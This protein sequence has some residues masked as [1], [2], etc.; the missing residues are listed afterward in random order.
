MAFPTLVKVLTVMFLWAVCFPL[1]TAGIDFAPHLTFATLRALLAGISLTCLAFIL[2]RPLPQGRR[3][4]MA[5]I[6]I[7]VTATSVGFFGMFHAAEF[8]APGLAT[9]VASTQPLLAAIFAG[10]FLNERLKTAGKIGLIIGFLGIVAISAPQLFIANQQNYILG[11]FYIILAALGI[12]I[13][14]VLMKG[15]THKVDALMAMGLQILFGSIPLG[16]MAVT[17]ED[18]TQV[19]WSFPFVSSLFALSLLG[20][21]LAYWLWFSALEKTALSQANAFSFLVPILGL[22]MGLIFYGES[23]SSLQITGIAL[24]IFGVALVARNGTSA[25]SVEHKAP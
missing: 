20:T 23:L 22:T 14:N 5:L 11:V 21:A 4:W 15:L 16:L 17:L 3:T 2:R 8:V 19:Q 13:S 25:N 6:A 7:G 10:L 24:S 9:V 12:T 1:I 18:P